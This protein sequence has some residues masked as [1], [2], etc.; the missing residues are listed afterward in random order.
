MRKLLAFLLLLF[1]ASSVWA[2]HT[3]IIIG[4]EVSAAAVAIEDSG[5]G[6]GPNQATCTI[7]NLTVTNGDKL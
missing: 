6:T 7:S 4:G 3:V 1:F 2:S 5:S